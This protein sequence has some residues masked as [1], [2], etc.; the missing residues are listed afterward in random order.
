MGL[1]FGMILE[2]EGRAW[3]DEIRQS[4]IG[5]WCLVLDL[6]GSLYH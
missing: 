2:F 5:I 6:S 3:S 1:D 4:V